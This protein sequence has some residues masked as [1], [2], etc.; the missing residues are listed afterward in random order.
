L[1]NFFKTRQAK[2]CGWVKTLGLNLWEWCVK[3]AVPAA[4]ASRATSCGDLLVR[5]MDNLRSD[6]AQIKLSRGFPQSLLDPFSSL[7]DKR[8]LEPNRD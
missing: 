3:A 6:H 8:G 7:E 5:L 2:S 4:N 1:W